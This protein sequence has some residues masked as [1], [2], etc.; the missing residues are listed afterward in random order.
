ML[1]SANSEQNEDEAKVAVEKGRGVLIFGRPCRTEMVKANRECPLPYRPSHSRSDIAF[2][3]TFV[4]YSRRGEETTVDMVREMLEPYGELSK[5]QLLSAQMQTAMDLPT[6]VLIEF[7]K[8][9]PKRD[10]NSVSI[11]KPNATSDGALDMLTCSHRLSVSTTVIVSTP[12]MPRTGASSR[13]PTPTRNT[14]A[15]TTSTV[16]LSSS[17]VSPS[18]PPKKSSSSTSL[19]S[20]VRSSTPTSSGVPAIRVRPFIPTLPN[21]FGPAH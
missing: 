17:A 2:P 21:S 18:T 14:F 16:V 13:A 3:G 19:P 9:D 10:L 20:W 12:S 11:T 4:V 8:F 15:S 5:C 1:D 6:A 7:A